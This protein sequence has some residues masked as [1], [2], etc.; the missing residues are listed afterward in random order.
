M[1]KTDAKNVF[2]A[3]SKQFALVQAGGNKEVNGSR[4]SQL[5]LFEISDAAIRFS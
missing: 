2:Y 4:M 1:C 3:M 5:L